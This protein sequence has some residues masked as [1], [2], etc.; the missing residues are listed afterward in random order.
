[1]NTTE[2]K[3]IFDNSIDPITGRPKHLYTLNGK[4]LTGVTT[5]LQVISKGD[6]LV[7][8]SAN[9]ACEYLKENAEKNGS[10]YAVREEQF[11]EARYAWK[12]S[13]DTA[14]TFGTTVHKAV[15]NF[16]KGEALPEMNDTE[17]KAF[18]QFKTWAED[19]NVK[20][21]KSEE[22]VYSKE[23]WY[24]GTIDLVLEIN[25]EYWIGDVKTSGSIY[26]EYFFQTSA[27]QYAL[28]ERGFD[29]KIEG[30]VIINMK[31]TG[32]F[33]VKRSYGYERNI[34]GFL[35]ALEIYRIKNQLKLEIK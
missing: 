33:E 4:P 7:Q 13:R 19:N 16:I 21:V 11:E 8:W 26:P 9:K 5:I 10:V 34:K 23:H 20:F 35:A 24:A 2:D 14:G 29:K 12:N 6:A 22:M 27:Y 28:Q 17:A 31:K 15:E 32:G 3:F 25:G 18:G 30:H 1:M